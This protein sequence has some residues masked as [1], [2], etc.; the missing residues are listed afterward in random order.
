MSQ[1]EI[2]KMVEIVGGEEKLLALASTFPNRRLPG[3]KYV[4]R[5]LR[6]RFRKEF[7][8]VDVRGFAERYSV[9]LQTIYNWS[10]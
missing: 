2:Q 8:G 1:D 9:S 4:N 5:V 6:A 3:R 10:R 7:K